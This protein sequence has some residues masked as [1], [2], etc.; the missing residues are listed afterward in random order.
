MPKA[1]VQVRWEV[2]YDERFTRLAG[3]GKADA[4]PEFNHAVHIEATGLA[5]DRVYYYRFRAGNWISP[6]GRTRTA[7]ARG[8]KN[9]E[10]RLGVA[11]ARRTTTA[12]TR[13][14]GTWPRRTWMWSSTSATTC[15][16]TRWTPWAAPA[17][18]PTAS[19][20]R[21]STARR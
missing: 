7:P 9:N 13:P 16:S 19:C 18:T 14:T 12:T 17:S 4:H 11:P 10:L 8:A 1:R 20:P 15:T 6:V 2:A 21:A 3:R 5:P